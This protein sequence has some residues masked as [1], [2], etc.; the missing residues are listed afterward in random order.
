MTAIYRIL[1]I[2]L[3]NTVDP[4]ESA[5]GCRANPPSAENHGRDFRT[6]AR[7]S[8]RPRSAEA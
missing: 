5:P 8:E 6:H 2:H 4:I 3:R 7:S 1:G